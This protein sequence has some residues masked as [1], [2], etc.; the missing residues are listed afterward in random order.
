VIHDLR[1]ENRAPTAPHRIP[2]L[3]HAASLLHDPLRFLELLE[4]Y[5][6]IVKI[7]MGVKPAYFI[8]DPELIHRILVTESGKFNKGKV[9]DKLSAF[10][11]EGLVHFSGETHLRRRRLIQPAFRHGRFDDYITIMSRL[12][13]ARID[14]WRPG[15]RMA[16]DEEMQ[17]LALAVVAK[18]LFSSELGRDAAVEIERSVPILTRGAFRRV[19]SPGLMEKVPTPG[20]RLFAAAI[21]R[22]RAVIEKVIESYHVDGADHGDLLSALLTARDPET[23]ERLS[24]AQVRDEIITMTIA[25]GETT[26]SALAWSFYELSRHPAVEERLRSEVDAVLGR[27]G[28]SAASITKLTYTSQIIEEVL[29][30]HPIWLTGRRTNTVVELGGVRIPANT[31]VMISPHALHRSSRVFDDA[32]RFDPG[33]WDPAQIKERARTAAIS[34]GGGNTQCPGE[35]FARTEMITTIAT[36]HADWRL[37]LAPGQRITE[38]AT[39]AVH[40]SSLNMIATPR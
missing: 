34:F 24:D 37:R 13:Q 40:P 35:T 23:G 28:V 10:F 39:A 25:G 6:P 15:Q 2:L 14:A 22:M 19:V 8:N 31:D 12:I 11:G 17:G 33:R 7:Y 5:G 26:G 27:C 32:R 18:S 29:R 16:V 9:H 4:P 1:S 21:V 30:L 20:N 3:G 38:K 36:V